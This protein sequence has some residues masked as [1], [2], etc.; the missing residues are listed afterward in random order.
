M[1]EERPKVLSARAFVQ[2]RQDTAPL[3][4]ERKLY[5][6]HLLDKGTSALRV[7]DVASRLLDIN[8]LLEMT[9]V[10]PISN[11]ELD[12]AA[13]KWLL[14]IAAHQKRGVLPSTEATFRSTA[15]RWLR[16]LGVRPLRQIGLLHPFTTELAAFIN[17]QQL[18]SDS[19]RNHRVNVSRFLAWAGTR[20]T[21]LPEISMESID[22]FFAEQRA[23]GI[24]P[25]SLASYCSSLRT[26]FRY[27][28]SQGWC[29]PALP[30][31]IKNPPYHTFGD[32]PSSPSWRDVRR[33]LAEHTGTTPAE[34]R[35]KAILFVCATYG[36][37]AVEVRRL[38][39]SDL[40]WSTE[41]IIIRRAK[42][43]PI[44]VFPLQYEVGE[45]VLRYLKHARPCCSVNELFVSLRPPHRPMSRAALIALVRRRMKASN[46]N[47]ERYGAHSIRHSCATQL[48]RR[49]SS[50]HAIA[51]F[52]GHR[53]IKSVSIYAK[54]DNNSL[55]RI[56]GFSLASLR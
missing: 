21:S 22:A 2:L 35:A 46:I 14:H 44:Q 31:G 3:R 39:T 17:S 6:E 9:R 33:M 52:L 30:R 10:R 28:A 49:G 42:G 54:L 8:R 27:A 43:G 19:V 15:E 20:H 50:L 18:S 16:F 36:L 55:R 5:L 26:F 45:A 4:E 47:T 12:I 34:L 56:A 11:A 38:Q 32:P 53:D 40:N 1:P 25:R 51:A 7:R 24:K 29:A 23:K 13:H 37:R 48:L 41:T